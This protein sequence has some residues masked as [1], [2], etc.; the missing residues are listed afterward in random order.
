M[1]KQIG[2]A[3]MLLGMWS[4]ASANESTY[5]ALMAQPSE[6]KPISY[7]FQLMR[8]GETLNETTFSA[9]AT[10]PVDVKNWRE[11]VITPEIALKEG[12]E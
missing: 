5:D 8:D 6:P 9:V 2:V 4:S 11:R 7:Q 10:L 1:K 12:F 3:L